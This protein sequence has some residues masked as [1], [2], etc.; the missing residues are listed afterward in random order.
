M[1]ENKLDLLMREFGGFVESESARLARRLPR[2]YCDD[3]LK[4][5]GYLAIIKYCDRFGFPSNGTSGAYVSSVMNYIHWAMMDYLRK[6]DIYGR[7]TKGNSRG[8]KRIDVDV[9]D[10]ARILEG[11]VHYD[12]GHVEDDDLVGAIE[13]RLNGEERR[14]FHLRV[15]EGLTYDKIGIML[16]VTDSNI[17]YKFNKLRKRLA[18]M[19]DS[20]TGRDIGRAKQMGNNKRREN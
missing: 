6:S 5:E 14:L 20:L 2:D 15:V 7:R 18:D 1:V 19:V 3:D 9:Y 4:Q 17:C 11:L 13:N 12:N 8:V 10:D 16:G